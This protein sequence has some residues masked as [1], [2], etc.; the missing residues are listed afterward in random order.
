MDAQLAII[1]RV[2]MQTLAF[3]RLVL[4]CMLACCLQSPTGMPQRPAVTALPLATCKLVLFA[5]GTGPSGP[6]RD[7][8]PAVAGAF[9]RVGRL[10]KLA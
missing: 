10:A 6:G 2:S 9:A 7:A 1:C 8:L 5:C 3:C 4:Y